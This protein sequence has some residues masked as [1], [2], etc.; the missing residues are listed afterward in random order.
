M[1]TAP[2]A[3][4]RACGTAVT[5]VV[6][7][8][9]SR[10]E[11]SGPR[12]PVTVTRSR[13]KSM[14]SPVRTASTPSRTRSWSAGGSP[15]P[16]IVR[17][18]RRRWRV[19]ANGTPPSILAVSNAPSPTVTPWST[20]LTAGASASTRA[21]STQ[22]LIPL[23]RYTLPDTTSAPEAIPTRRAAFSSVSSHSATAD[24]APGDPGAGAEPEDAAPVGTP[25]GPEGTDADGELGLVA[26]GVDPA[27]GAA[28]RAARGR[29]EVG[30]GEQGRVLRG[31]AHRPRRE[32]GPQDLGPADAL[33]QPAADVGDEVDQARVLLDPAEVVDL[34]GA[35]PA[36]GRE[37]V[38]DEVDDHDVLGVVLGEQAL[39]GGGR[40]LDRARGEPVAAADEERL[41]RGA[42][43]LQPD[44]GQVDR[45][46]VGGRVARGE[47]RAER[48]DR[49]ALGEVVLEDAAE[50]DLVD[51][52]GRDPPTDL[53][54]PGDVGVAVQAGAPRPVERGPLPRFRRRRR[55]VDLGHPHRGEVSLEGHDDDPEALGEVGRVVGGGRDPAGHDR[56]E[57]RLRHATHRMRQGRVR[58]RASRSARS[59]RV[60]SCRRIITRSPQ[61][62]ASDLGRSSTPAPPLWTT[63]PTSR[64]ADAP[65]STA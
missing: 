13:P 34:D 51:G 47:A 6:S 65:G 20:A 23:M 7:A 17:S 19:I 64:V 53:V 41:R 3:S 25:V 56:P 57:P 10:S 45:R 14:A 27:H 21:P 15:S 48:G 40:A 43:D 36:D 63:M 1:T 54:D 44:L 58:P 59:R 22:T 61:A 38:A 18:R 33:A 16:A 24:A 46:G 2:W 50:V 26:V 35:R 8:E 12:P 52:A 55:A 4:G 31:A 39:G 5:M 30:D 29:L 42:G 49:G 32:G 28:V 62:R 11:P 60:C 37:V 9:S